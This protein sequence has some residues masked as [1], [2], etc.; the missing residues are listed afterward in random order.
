MKRYAG[1]K[2]YAIVTIRMIG[3]RIFLNTHQSA[4]SMYNGQVDGKA[5]INLVPKIP[6]Q[7]D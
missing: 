1:N 7:K 5:C 2:A 4:K 3:K 6:K